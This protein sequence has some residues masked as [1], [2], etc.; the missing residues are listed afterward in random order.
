MIWEQNIS[1]C[2]PNKVGHELYYLPEFPHFSE[3]RNQYIGVKQQPPN[4]T[5]TK[6]LL[7][8]DDTEERAQLA[9]FVNHAGY[10]RLSGQ[11]KGNAQTPES[12]VE[13]MYVHKVWCSVC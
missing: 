10:E 2:D 1:L 7:T 4:P 13:N 11:L 12:K 3:I 5:Q 8:P 6:W 9:L